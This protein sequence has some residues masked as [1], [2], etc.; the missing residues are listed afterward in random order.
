MSIKKRSF[1]N[2]FS[3]IGFLI[4]ILLVI[5]VLMIQNI[6]SKAID[7]TNSEMGYTV[8]VDSELYAGEP[9]DEWIAYTAADGKPHAS[10]LTTR[11]DGT[12]VTENMSLIVPR[13]N[14]DWLCTA[15]TSELKK[16]TVN[17]VEYEVTSNCADPS[18]IQLQVFIKYEEDLSDIKFQF[19]THNSVVYKLNNKEFKF[20][21]ARYDEMAKLTSTVAVR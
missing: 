3:T 2:A 6:V 4:F 15:I 13:V 16:I 17:T 5:G 11:G 19:T 1:K 7:Q 10:I 12:F 8:E 9:E 20:N 18:D 21:S 14:S